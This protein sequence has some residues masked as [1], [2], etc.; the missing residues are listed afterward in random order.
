MG[1][2]PINNFLMQ[3]VLDILVC[4]D[5]GPVSAGKW[6]W[7]ATKASRSPCSP[8]KWPGAIGVW[9]IPFR[10]DGM[11]LAFAY[12]WMIEGEVETRG[13][14]GRPTRVRSNGLRTMPYDYYSLWISMVTA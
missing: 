3:T 4:Y 2:M 10:P 7:W 12:L 6:A 11:A 13:P 14:S 1:R 5:I 8:N 9:A